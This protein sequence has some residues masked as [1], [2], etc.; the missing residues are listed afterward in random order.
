MANRTLSSATVIDRGVP[1]ETVLRPL[2]FSVYINDLDMLLSAD[3][4]M[5]C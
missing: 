2:L 1:Q 4:S 3:D 5:M